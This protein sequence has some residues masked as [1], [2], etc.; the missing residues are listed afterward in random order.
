MYQSIL[1][2]LFFKLPAE[3][4]HNLAF[5]I[6]E[7]TQSMTNVLPR[8]LD[9]KDER[10]HQ[11][12]W[13]IP[14]RN[15]IG[16]AGG[17]DKNARC[18]RWWD[19]LGFSFAEIGTV[20]PLPQIGN[21]KPRM[22]RYPE[23]H[24]IVNRMG[25]N[26]DGSDAIRERLEASSKMMNQK[27]FVLGVSIGKQKETPANEIEQVIR[28][29]VSSIDKL[30][31]YGDYFA[32][33]VSSPNTK[34][35]RSLQE[36]NA[37]EQLLRALLET[38]DELAAVY[39]HPK[40]KPLCVKI[41]PDITREQLEDITEVVL[42]NKIDGIIATNTTN[43]TANR[44]TGGLSG[45]PL[46]VKSTE[47]I[48]RISQLTDGNVPIIGCGGIF[49]AEDAIEKLQAGAW[50]LQ[51]YTGIVYEGPAMVYSMNK[52]LVQYIQ[53]NGLESIE[54]IRKQ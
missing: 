23:E 18:I 3:T 13:G 16:L 46:R 49:T 5:S 36:R 47:V 27:P 52:S 34:D 12:I 26:N 11:S 29:Y 6:L 19:W 32:V 50:L 22:F 43:Q 39:N 38:L 14:F 7:S 48:H 54:K 42:N 20:T 33:N 30:Y 24:A 37:L 45:V 4:A 35:L 9:V 15:P 41:A 44:E 40:R 1:R 21:P 10:L 53:K 17:F 2:P 28:D 25:F 51:V 8:M 31:L